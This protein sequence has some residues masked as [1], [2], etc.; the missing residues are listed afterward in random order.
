MKY[1]SSRNLQLLLVLFLTS[2][3]ISCSSS[4][5]STPDE[6]SAAVDS[7]SMALEDTLVTA[8][9]SLS[10]GTAQVVLKTM[11]FEESSTGDVHIKTTI[12]KV[13]GYGPATPPIAPG[14]ELEI[15][16]T[17]YFKNSEQQP[18]YYSARD[19]V[20]CLIAHG[21]RMQMGN[22]GNGGYWRLMNILN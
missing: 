5:K 16:A 10:P 9:K 14:Q 7:N 3:F 4:K 17:T 8:P 20:I 18:D 1:Q 11:T 6:Q 13:M 2:T 22:E 21:Q 15:D 12:G 19:S